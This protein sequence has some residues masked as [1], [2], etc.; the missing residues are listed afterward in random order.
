EELHNNK[1]VCPSCNFQY[2]I[3]ARNRLHLFF[4]RDSIQEH[5]ANVSPVYMLKFKYT[6]TYKDRLAQSQKKTEEQDALVVM[7]GTVKG[8]HEVAA[9][10][11][12]MFL[13]GSMGS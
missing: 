11:N 6:K 9:A 4:D 5:F 7:E 8:F 2:R 3:Y 10:Y 1:S 13:R 12:F